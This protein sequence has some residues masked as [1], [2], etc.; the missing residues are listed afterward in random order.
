MTQRRQAREIAIH[1]LYALDISKTDAKKAL[2]NHLLLIAGFE[3]EEMEEL[4]MGAVTI[5]VQ[6]FAQRLVLGTWQNLS[7]IDQLIIAKTN[8][9]DFARL[10]KTDKAILRLACFEMV[11]CEDI[12]PRVS[13]NEAIEL[14]KS[15]GE[16]NSPAFVNGILDGISV[17]TAK[18]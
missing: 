17:R 3:K 10:V 5:A 13:I 7:A 14:A 11:Y 2:E 16:E 4:G 9:W 6:D 1:V 18:R 15:Y 12:P 8:N